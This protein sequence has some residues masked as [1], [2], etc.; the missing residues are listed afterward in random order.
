MTERALSTTEAQCASPC[1]AMACGGSAT[2]DRIEEARQR[3]VDEAGPLDVGA[4]ADVVDLEQF[5]ARDSSSELAS[6]PGVLEHITTAGHD[7]D[8]R[9]DALVRGRVLSTEVSASGRGGAP[10]LCR[11][12]AL[13]RPRT[14]AL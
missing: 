10:E 7:E 9:R 4:V 3:V 6:V 11:R 14:K 5:A 13:P 12:R 8:G 2:V 1:A